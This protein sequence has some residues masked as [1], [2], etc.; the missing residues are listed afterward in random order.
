M[1]WKRVFEYRAQDIHAAKCKRADR[2]FAQNLLKRVVKT[3]AI[4]AYVQPPPLVSSSSDES[5]DEPGGLVS[6]SSDE[7]SDGEMPRGHWQE[8]PM[9]RA[10]HTLHGDDDPVPRTLADLS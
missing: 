7:S 4:A 6:S 2:A 1:A 3:W 9:W 10:L 5:G 8:D